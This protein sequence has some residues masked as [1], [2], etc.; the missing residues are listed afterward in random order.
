MPRFVMMLALILTLSTMV[1]SASPFD[2]TRVS[3]TSSSGSTGTVDTGGAVLNVRSGPWG[4]IVA[5]FPDGK[6]L[7]ISGSSGDWYKISHNGKT[8]YVHKN[9]VTTSAKPASKKSPVQTKTG[10]VSTGG[11]ILNIRS[12]PWGKIVGSLKNG[13]SVKITG[14]SGDWYKISH[15][16]KTG[17]IHKNY[18]STATSSASQKEPFKPYNATVRTGG[19]PL[20]V[21]SGPWGNIVGFLSEGSSVK[22]T[23][24]SGDWLLISFKG[25]TRYVHKDYIATGAVAAKPSGAA[26]ASPGNL[27]KA[28]VIGKP[29]GDGS[30]AGA[31][32]WARDQINGTKNGY[33]VNNG[34][35]SRNSTAWAGWCLA[36]VN[37]AY[38]RSKSL[39]R[40]PS[41]IKSYYQF[42]AAG[43]INTSK[44]PPAGAAMFTGT[45]P[46][47]PYGHVFIATGRMNGPNDPII[48]TTTGNGI[49]E[50]PMSQ[51]WKGP[52]YLGWAIP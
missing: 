50:M 4:N 46:G 49:K 38:G 43:K 52:A 10:K 51:M 29:M 22:V 18:V 23:G 15:D 7:K 28:S 5:K 19:L 33:N 21:R 36:F 20:N 31:L 8:A 3:L 1:G 35:T 6:K 26:G 13:A 25:T 45:V 27:H 32:T 47:N 12:G 24:K 9:F 17:Y 11:A 41:A 34:K 44:N 37:T 40:A 42:K 39:L 2:E 48:I 16:G 30:V 14:S